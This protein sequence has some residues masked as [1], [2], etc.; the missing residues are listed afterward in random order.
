MTI[1]EVETHKV[2]TVDDLITK[3]GITPQQIAK[4]LPE[5]KQDEL[6]GEQEAD[7][8]GDVPPNR[9]VSYAISHGINNL[10]IDVFSFVDGDYAVETIESEPYVIEIQGEWLKE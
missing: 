4:A 1:K 2:E 5:V 10:L 3:V 8:L 9:V 6:M 7:S